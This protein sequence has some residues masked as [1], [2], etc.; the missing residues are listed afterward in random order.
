MV[1]FVT[2]GAVRV[3]L[4]KVAAAVSV[5]ITPLTGKV[6]LELIPV[7]PK[8]EPKIPVTAALFAK[9]IAPNVGTPPPDGT[10][11]T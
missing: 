9:L 8:A 7:P 11:S 4:V 1:P 10:V 2:T 3:L 6:A 5:T